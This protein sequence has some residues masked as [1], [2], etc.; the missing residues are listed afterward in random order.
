MIL[1]GSVPA[2]YLSPLSGISLAAEVQRLRSHGVCA[3]R[4][5][6]AFMRAPVPGKA[7]E[8]LYLTN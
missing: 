3:F 8:E 7:L 6:E 5:G 1:T 4:V 2:G